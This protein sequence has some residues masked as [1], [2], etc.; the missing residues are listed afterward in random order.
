MPRPRLVIRIH[1]QFLQ[2]RARTKR[3][4]RTGQTSRISEAR[5]DPGDRGL[6]GVGPEAARS[7]AQDQGAHALR[8]R[9]RTGEA[10]PAAHRLTDE[11]GALY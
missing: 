3:A 1:R 10:S 9:E 8:V 6:D 7:A 11:R 5:A 2:I 4:A